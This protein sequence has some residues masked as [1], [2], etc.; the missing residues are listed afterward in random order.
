MKLKLF[1]LLIALSACN[2]TSG[3][4]ATNENRDFLIRDY[5][6]CNQFNSTELARKSG[7]AYSLAIAAERR[8]GK[9]RSSVLE[10][11][12]STLGPARA[13]D[14][15]DRQTQRQIQINA[16]MIAELRN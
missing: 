10:S 13:M 3:Q 12:A 4:I 11:L 1:P 7:D 14:F 16:G 8:C 9:Y 5:V 6:R 2:S 15:M